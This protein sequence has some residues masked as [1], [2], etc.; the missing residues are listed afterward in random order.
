V[1]FPRGSFIVFDDRPSDSPYV[2]RV[3]RSHSERAGTFHS[4]AANHWEMVVT[5]HAG[6][7]SVTVRG[8]ETRATTA[9]CPADGEWMGIRFRLGTFMPALPAG[10]LRDRRDVTLPDLSGRS[11]QL[12]ASAW[13][14]PD[15]ENAETFVQRLVRAGLVAM[16]P[17]VDAVLHD[18]R[19]RPSKRTEQRHFLQATGITLATIRQVERARHATTLL[20]EG[21]NILD[22]VHAAGYFDQSHLTRSVKRLIGQTPAQIARGEEQLSFLY[23]TTGSGSAIAPAHGHHPPTLARPL[24]ARNHH[25]RTGDSLSRL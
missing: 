7:T 21:V 12:D 19:T 11:F 20:R 14:Y 24:L 2:E 5:R 6:T 8:P 22:V 3:W 18:D 9:H 23:N 17:A 13:E 4:M 10:A 16:D 15:F 1:S 25:Q